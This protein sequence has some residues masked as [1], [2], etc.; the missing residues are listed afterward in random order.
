MLDDVMD[1]VMDKPIGPIVRK[2]RAE[3]NLDAL[4]EN[5]D[6]IWKRCGSRGYMILLKADAY[7]HGAI[8]VAQL[9]EKKGVS[10][11]GV[12]S[13]QEAHYLR[14]AGVKL[15]LLILEDLFPDEIALALASNASLTASSFDYLRQVAAVTKAL[16][17]GKD[18]DLGG[19][20]SA[21]IHLNVDTGMG[22]LG[23]FP[24]EAPTLV[25]YILETPCLELEGIYTHFPSSDEGRP[26]KPRG[27]I[28]RFKNLLAELKAEGAQP[29]WVHAANSGAAIDLSV[30]SAFDLVRPGLA[31]FGLYPAPELDHTAGL[32][33]VMRLR[34]AVL[35]VKRFP[36]GYPIGY[37]ST[38]VT[39]RE[40]RI[41]IVPIGYGDGYLRDFSGKGVVVVHGK[42]VP[43]V[44]RVSMDMITIDLT[45]LPEAVEPG[46]EVVLAGQQRWEDRTG[47]V[48]IEE[49]SQIVSTITYEITCLIGKRV[50]RIFQEGG[51]PVAAES[52]SGATFRQL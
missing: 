24:E 14:Q 27:Q 51:K 48:S 28:A 16:S 49:L 25:R 30:E 37:G 3:I 13:C 39:I 41:G 42:R 29:A 15:P 19:K 38:F 10:F 46:D 21:K 8:A 6:T 2:T 9:A 4:S 45:D 5:I 20:R 26:E 47:E 36:P 7:G 44:G 12:S 34:S 33:Q 22:R 23:C 17:E 35:M 1:D 43:V 18:E 32:K 50:P 52:M 11:G 31:S 40:S